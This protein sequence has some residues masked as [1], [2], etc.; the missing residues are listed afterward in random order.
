MRT[1]SAKAVNGSSVVQK[2]ATNKQQKSAEDK[3][4][5]FDIRG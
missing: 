4:L 1:K 3:F 2:K 5:H